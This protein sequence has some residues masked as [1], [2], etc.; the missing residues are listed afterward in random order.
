MSP[1][2]N[3]PDSD[4]PQGNQF[5]PTVPLDKVESSVPPPDT[6]FI[7][8]IDL[9][10]TMMEDWQTALGDDVAPGKTIKVPRSDSDSLSNTVK[11]SDE[12]D[13]TQT[14]PTGTG[15][16]DDFVI[17]IGYEVDQLLGEGGMGVVYAGRQQSMDRPVAIKVL[18]PETEQSDG[19]QRAFTSEAII[20]GGLDHPNIVPI[21]DLGK[22]ADD[23]LFYAM[24]QVEG[25]EWKDRIATNSLSENLD[26]LL[27]VADA[28]AFAHA[29][30]I[31][32]RD[33]KPANIMLGSF[34]EVLLM[35]WGLAMPTQDHPRRELYHTPA[36]GGTPYYMAP[37]M[38]NG[39]EQ[40]DRRSDVYLLGGILFEMITGKPPHTLDA[41]PETQREHVVACLAAVSQNMIAATEKT[42]ELLDIARKAMATNPADRYQ[43]VPEF[44]EAIRGYL[45]HEE[46]IE[47]AARAAE[48]LD[49]ARKN[50]D[51]EE[52]SRT[53][54]GFETA[55]EEWPENVRAQE[56]L[57]ATKYDYAKTALDRGDLDQGLSLLDETNAEHSK[58]RSSIQTAI[59]KRDT[60]QQ[61]VRRLKR[62]SFAAS[63]VVALVASVATVWINS[64]RDKALVAQDKA[65]AAQKEEAIQREQA[66]RSEQE[67]QEQRLLAIA[68]REKAL[69]AQKIAQE[70]EKKAIAAEARAKQEAQKALHN[71]K[72]AERNGYYSDM[73]LLQKAWQDADPF[74][75]I[76]ILGRYRKRED[77]RGF[78]WD[79]WNRMSQTNLLSFREHS[80]K[81]TDIAYS[82]DGTKIASAA[83][84][85]TVKVWDTRTWT[86]KV[87]AE[88]YARGL[89][90]SLRQRVES[91]EELQKRVQEDKTLSEGVKN[92]AFEWA[93]LFW[94][95]RVVRNIPQ[96]ESGKIEAPL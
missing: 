52:F 61:Q 23:A 72:I 2:D 64:E 75:L 83:T 86:A 55:L 37:E 7:P 80:G 70:N 92:Q 13:A 88:Y 71:F 34:G 11:L 47:L 65:L 40:V 93:E 5:N 33:L 95:N 50:G 59:V 26:I 48:R 96:P 1:S 67:A 45:S 49:V 60:R 57:K 42:G 54:F 14:Y 69:V 73:L 56:G 6:T 36:P 87:Q 24:K 51:Y 35:D 84:D 32:H 12:L 74:K 18:K 22:Q 76:Q 79:Y 82:P 68:A 38:I 31:I 29:R 17:G 58:L 8:H 16:D 3:K 28:V 19:S 85:K 25:V 53:R 90:I 81:V 20:T 27:R 21:Y 62:V 41:P 66:Q 4:K 43:S 46:S 15:T 44:Q 77:L 78:E 30:C 9:A 89:L 94:K 63:L 91:L 10:A 39:V